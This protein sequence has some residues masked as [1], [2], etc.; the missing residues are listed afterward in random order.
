MQIVISI[1]DLPIEEICAIIQALK[2]KPWCITAQAQPADLT[3][4][5]WS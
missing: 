5:D 4:W 2:Q 1:P 3:N